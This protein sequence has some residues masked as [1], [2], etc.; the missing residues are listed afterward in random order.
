MTTI[1]KALGLLEHFSSNKP[2]IGLIEFRRL[3]GF[4]KGTVHRYLTSLRYAGF[5]EQNQK[6]RA[7]RLGP[8]IIRLAAV[9]E[10]TFPM[11][12]IIAPHVDH[13]A[14]TTQ[15]LVHASLPQPQGMSALYYKDGG[16]SGTRVGFEEAEILPLHATAS[17]ISMMAFG[18]SRI[19]EAEITR[20]FQK[21]TDTTPL[22]VDSVKAL[23]KEAQKKGYAATNQ[24]F[25]DDVYSIA[26]PF[27]DA[28]A[29]AIGTLALATPAT[30]MDSSNCVALARL[31]ANTALSVTQDLGGSITPKLAKM[32]DDL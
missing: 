13:L 5:L 12:K 15:E 20:P 17:G 10:Q 21:F 25:E 6:T 30:R 22:T 9:R 27:F 18:P 32:W 24:S 14:N 23:I 11:V 28:D 16:H 19:L 7:Y 2:E 3:S 31:L 26:M 4:D 1:K 8:A 29:A